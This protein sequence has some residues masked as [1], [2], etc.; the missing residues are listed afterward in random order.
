[1]CNLLRSTPVTGLLCALSLGVA[2]LEAQETGLRL[3]ITWGSGK[4]QQWRGTL[5]IDKG[6]FSEIR[7]LGLEADEPGSMELDNRVVHIDQRS[8]RSYDGADLLVTAPLDTKLSIEL[9]IGPG[10]WGGV[11]TTRVC[12]SM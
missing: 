7:L 2:S 10:T 11:T 4:S 5:R 3:R 9:S 12:P 1:M 6:T 8:P